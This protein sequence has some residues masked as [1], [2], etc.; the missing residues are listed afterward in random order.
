MNKMNRLGS[1]VAGLGNPGPG[2]PQPLHAFD[3]T[4]LEDQ[5]DHVEFMQSLNLSIS[6]VD[7]V[8][9]LVVT[10]SCYMCGTPGTGLPT[11]VVCILDHVCNY[12]W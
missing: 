4:D 8:W 2:G 10:R 11:P 12:L 7:Q 5:E 9:C 6:S 1:C 3:L